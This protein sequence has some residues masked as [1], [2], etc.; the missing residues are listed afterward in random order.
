LVDKTFN[1]ENQKML[2]LF[3][4]SSIFSCIGGCP[5]SCCA[6]PKQLPQQTQSTIVSET[7]PATE[8]PATIDKPQK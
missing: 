4:L 8:S 7:P 3:L 2:R 5:L 6:T 1:R